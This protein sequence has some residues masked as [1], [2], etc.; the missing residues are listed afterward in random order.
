[1]LMVLHDAAVPNI[2]RCLLSGCVD[3]TANTY[4]AASL[5]LCLLQVTA[6]AVVPMKHGPACM[7]VLGTSNMRPSPS[8]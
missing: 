8:V 5:P 3:S 6:A 1:M 2:V 7:Q 4:E